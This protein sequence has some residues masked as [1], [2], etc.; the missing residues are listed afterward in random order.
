[1]NI[2][3]D[4]S[5]VQ[6]I[7]GTYRIPIALGGV[8]LFLL[9]TA[10]VLLV[11]SIQTPK[12]IEFISATD[13]G[14]GEA[15]V[16]GIQSGRV[17]VDV[18]GAIVHPGLYWVAFDA[19]VDDVITQAG[20]M[21]ADADTEWVAKTINRAKRVSDGMK[22]Y[23]PSGEETSHIIEAAND[24]SKTSY[25]ISS[26]SNGQVQGLVSVNT[27]SQSQLEALTGIGPVTAQKIMAN[28]PYGDLQEL[29]TKKVM[30]QS[31]FTKLSGQL[32]L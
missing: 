19:R 28:R 5:S 31:L 24:G 11:K 21:S 8:S 4:R 32:S 17:A 13:A 3:S 1:M 14:N 29:V 12:P 7:V 9:G 23:I 2:G 15:S 30:S 22:I 18:A 26:S 6:E 27:A 10:V 16:A 25:N 20:G